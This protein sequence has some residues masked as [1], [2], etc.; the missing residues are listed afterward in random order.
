MRAAAAA[1]RA[2]TPRPGRRLRWTI[3]VPNG[4]RDRYR[5]M[6][7]RLLA[8]GSLA[9]WAINTTSAAAFALEFIDRA[10]TAPLVLLSLVVVL[11]SGSA[12]VVLARPFPKVRLLMAL[13]LA[14]GLV[15]SVLLLKV[16]RGELET[17][18]IMF[19]VLLGMIGSASPLISMLGPLLAFTVP[20]AAAL[21][22]SGTLLDQGPPLLVY[23][24]AMP[25]AAVAGL[26]VANR[27]VGVMI[28][29]L[30]VTR[31]R[32]DSSEDLLEDF[33]T[34]SGNWLWTTDD[35]LHLT[36]MS[37]Q[38]ARELGER[39]ADPILPA[40][41]SVADRARDAAGGIAAFEA[42]VK[43]RASFRDIVLPVRLGRAPY[44]ISVTGKAVAAADGRFS[45]YH[46]VAFD[47]T[48]SHESEARIASLARTD[49][50]TGL[51][52]RASFL[53][54]LER[55]CA[56]GSGAGLVL[57]DIQDFSAMND[58]LGQRAGDALLASLASRL[59]EA[60]G[61]RGAVGRLGGDE[62]G[63]LFERLSRAAV[64]AEVRRVRNAVTLPYQLDDAVDRLS[65]GV[66]V[67]IAIAPEDAT[68]AAGLLQGASLALAAARREF[69][70]G[71]RFFEPAMLVG[72]QE[73]NAI[74]SDLRHAARRGE[75][76]VRFQPV[77]DLR[78]GRV[79]SA[80]ALLR[81]RHPVRGDVP[82]SSFIPVAEASGLISQLGGF[83]LVEACRRAA[84]WPDGLRVAV[85]VSASQFREAAL[86][87]TIDAACREAGLDPARL[88]LEVTESVLLD[89]SA[90]TIERFR[91]IRERGIRIILDDFGTGYSSLAYLLRLRFDKIK[92][93]QAFVRNIE[94][95]A[96]A[97]AIVAAIASL[98]TRFGMLTTIEGIERP[99]QLDAAR[100]LGVDEG[101]GFLFHPPLDADAMGRLVGGSTPVATTRGTDAVDA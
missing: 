28:L 43:A 35:T 1:P 96:G 101:Q 70:S 39:A 25:I 72:L 74:R 2:T 89:A 100:A 66:S 3:E 9:F 15:W 87:S 98:A 11:L 4:L 81:W 63:V 45:G 54:T 12:G 34:A 56:S 16:A 75:L 33:E 23:L 93:D 20:I 14:T 21:A 24:T 58:A 32:A 85:N 82:P 67:G 64:E 94:T 18:A 13:H 57:M 53:A 55:S 49:A 69:A 90:A 68:D 97:S 61:P 71:P 10:D 48:E 42:A 47:V 73:R 36:R 29:R 6:Q 41:G 59:A 7:L 60:V 30:V 19:G 31:A 17:R 91:E 79:V 62:F 86:L 76:S 99:S 51:A 77:V 46:G 37:P 8:R 27:L 78:T 5:S 22:I 26:A 80:E 95:N 40:L 84:A 92:I 88:D 50:L 44:W 83:A 38:I 52:N 65:I